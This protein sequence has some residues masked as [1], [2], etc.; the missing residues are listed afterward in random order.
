VFANTGIGI[1]L[2]GGT[3]TG[4]VTANDNKDVDTGANNLQNCPVLS[5]AT[6]ATN[7][8]AGTF[9]ST[10][11]STFA[12]E[13]LRRTGSGLATVVGTLSVTTDAS[14]NASISVTATGLA[15]GDVVYA[16][17]TSSSG[18][19]SELSASVTAA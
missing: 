9:N 17:A 2:V 16:T 5:S 10:P 1:D 12:I 6:V 4:G 7:V 14:G 8:V 19:T 15:A 13:V 18:D 11:N 3:E